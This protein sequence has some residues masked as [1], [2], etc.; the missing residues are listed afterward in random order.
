MEMSSQSIIDFM[1]SRRSVRARDMAAPGPTPD[2]LQQMLTIAARVP[3]HGKLAPWRFIV[4]TQTDCEELGA[5]GEHLA[6]ARAGA[7]G[8][9]DMMREDERLRFLRAP[10][11]V[12]VI[13]S[14][15]EHPKIPAWEQTLSAGAV[16][17]GLMIAAHG[18]GFA[19][20][21][22]TGWVAYDDA[23]GAR[24]RLQPNEAI[25]GFIH[26][27]SNPGP[28]PEDRPRPSLGDIVQYGL[29]RGD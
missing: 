22:L 3:D 8:L 25:A 13:A 29:E 19:A 26:I 15:Q 20:Q 4:L 27:G 9:T 7:E 17:Y 21:W 10:S 11:V 14:T 6:Q 1:K 12:C 24:L 18:M 23:F 28:A 2:Q 16:C 5:L